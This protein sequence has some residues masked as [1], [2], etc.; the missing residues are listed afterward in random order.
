MGSRVRSELDVIREGIEF[1]RNSLG[2]VTAK[3]PPGASIKDDVAE[4]IPIIKAWRENGSPPQGDYGTCDSCGMT[5]KHYRAG[6]CTLCCCAIQ[7][8][9]KEEEREYEYAKPKE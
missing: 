1:S 7:K 5:I 4:R 3:G 9:M 6:N 8:I 2:K